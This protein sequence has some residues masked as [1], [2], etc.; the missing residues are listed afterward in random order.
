LRITEVFDFATDVIADIIVTVADHLPR[1]VQ[2]HIHVAAHEY[3]TVVLDL[4]LA[5]RTARLG[6]VI[7]NLE[8]FLFVRR[9]IEV[10]AVGI[11]LDLDLSMS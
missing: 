10:V 8:D 4:D 6:Q 3:A 5:L 7:D 2:G 9:R 1:S 11:V